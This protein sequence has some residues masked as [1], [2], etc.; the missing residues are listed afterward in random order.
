L[1][2]GIFAPT[3]VGL[4][5]QLNRLNPSKMSQKK[6]SSAADTSVSELFA[7]QTEQIKEIVKSKN[8]QIKSYQSQLRQDNEDLEEQNQPQ[9]VKFEDLKAMA[10]EAGLNPL[11]LDMPFIKN[12]IKKYTKGMSIEEIIQTV[13]ELKKFV[14]SKGLGKGTEEELQDPTDIYLKQNRADNF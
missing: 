14:G 7:V 13:T 1:I 10:K 5:W 4:M 8:N 6:A 11:L 2:L 9:E 12:N 3:F